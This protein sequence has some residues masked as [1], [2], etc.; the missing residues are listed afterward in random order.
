M[1]PANIIQ[2]HI[3]ISA[4]ATTQAPKVFPKVI[5]D[6]DFFTNEPGV[7]ISSLYLSQYVLPEWFMNGTS[8]TSIIFTFRN[9]GAIARDIFAT[10]ESSLQLAA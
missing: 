1:D 5:V 2:P 8:R 10:N 6:R 7:E 9:E 4:T 3:I